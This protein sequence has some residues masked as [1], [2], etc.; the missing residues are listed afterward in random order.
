M[1]AAGATPEEMNAALQAAAGGDDGAGAGAGASAGAGAGTGKGDDGVTLTLQHMPPE[2]QRA[3]AL[4]GQ[5]AQQGQIRAAHEFRALVEENVKKVL[6]SD[7]TFSIMVKNE[8]QGSI[9]PWNTEGSMSKVLFDEFMDKVR[10]RVTEYPDRA[11]APEDYT[12]IAQ[13]MRHRWSALGK[14]MM[15]EQAVP[16]ALGAALGIAP[17]LQANEPVERVPATAPTYSANFAQ[18]MA[19]VF[20]EAAGRLKR[21]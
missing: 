20:A 21:A 19:R 13:T 2:V 6:T 12:G 8:A 4:T 3:V 7:P 10:S 1:R 16:T 11:L 18:R 17:K 9:V 14:V 5:Q 15:A